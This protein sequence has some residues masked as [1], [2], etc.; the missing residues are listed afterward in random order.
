MS[1]DV[2]L[3]KYDELFNPVLKALHALGGSGTVR[4][5][6]A[7]TAEI[8]NLPEDLLTI[9]HKKGS[10][11]FSYRLAWARNYL[12]RYGLLENSSRGVWALTGTRSISVDVDKEEVKRFVKGQ[13]K[14]KKVELDADED[15][16]ETIEESNGFD[17]KDKLLSEVMSLNPNEFERLAQRILRESGFVEVNVTGRSGD[18]GIDGKGLIKVGELISFPIIFQCKRYKNSVTSKEIRD[19]RG[20]MSGR[21]E[22]GLFLTTGTFTRDAK[23]EATR[24]GV[25]IIDLIDGEQLVEVLKRLNLGVSVSTKEVV[26]V[27][28]EWFKSF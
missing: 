15:N 9:P 20:A 24:D 14:N 5:I 13:F 7:K 22:K 12:K 6:D 28:K 23:N 17:W 4:E 18:E 3:P 2:Q 16:I 8:L 26:E 27:N 10:T 19:F 21:A 11:E 1:T 25:A